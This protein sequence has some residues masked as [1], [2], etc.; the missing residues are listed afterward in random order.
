MATAV[1]PQNE[2]HRCRR[3]RGWMGAGAGVTAILLLAGIAAAQT[4]GE[5]PKPAN[6]PPAAAPAQAP[7]PAAESPGFVGALG[8]WMQQGVTS[9]SSGFDAMVGAAKGA[10][11][12]ASTVAKGAT[13]AA[14]DA[15]G[16]AVGGVTKMPTAGF[17]SG[18]EQC[19][20]AGNGAPDCRVAA[21]ALCR[22][23][24]FG[25]GTS[26]DYETSEKCPPPYR[27]SGRDA[28]YRL[29]SQDRPQGICTTEHFVTRAFCK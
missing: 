6:D 22:S 5:P 19:T 18:R 8:N 20:L 24:G 27:T 12:A 3:R 13:D 21:E 17:A 7:P 10:A 11:D 15:A 4:R 9:M 23:R 1:K 26:I 28:P 14:K 29:S 25:T 16:V 2:P